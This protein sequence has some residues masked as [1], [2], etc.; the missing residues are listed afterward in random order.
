MGSVLNKYFNNKYT[1]RLIN[2]I[3]HVNPFNYINK[4]D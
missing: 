4:I 2:A 3:N 1:K